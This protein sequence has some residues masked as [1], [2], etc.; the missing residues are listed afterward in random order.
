[1]LNS[2][3]VFTYV[4]IEFFQDTVPNLDEILMSTSDCSFDILTLLD[5]CVISW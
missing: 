2:T 4:S 1:M 5:G 3:K